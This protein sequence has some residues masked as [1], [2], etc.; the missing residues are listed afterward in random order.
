VFGRLI[1]YASGV[2]GR[3]IGIQKRF[4]RTQD[5]SMGTRL[6]NGVPRCAHNIHGQLRPEGGYRRG[7]HAQYMRIQE[8]KEINQVAK[9]N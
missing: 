2:H 4:V 8:E 6:H 3:E 9:A 5:G 1:R 7:M